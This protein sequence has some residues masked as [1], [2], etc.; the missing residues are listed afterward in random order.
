MCSD[1][2][3]CHQ[4]RA[5]FQDNCIKFPLDYFRVKTHRKL[6]YLFG[7]T[8][9][10]ELR[11]RIFDLIP[12]QITI[13]KIVDYWRADFLL[14]FMIIVLLPTLDQNFWKLSCLIMSFF[15]L[16][17]FLLQNESSTSKRNLFVAGWV[18]QFVGQL[19]TSFAQV[20]IP[21]VA[22]RSKGCHLV[23]GFLFLNFDWK[24]SHWLQSR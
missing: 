14:Q 8:C 2:K 4:R 13:L 7:K 18:L 20:L 22:F 17:D 21:K 1:W 19:Y 10:Y 12:I 16:L 24:R 9:S 23:K 15:F 3:Y 11:Q 5:T 6:H